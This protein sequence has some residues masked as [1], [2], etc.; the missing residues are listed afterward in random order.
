M[1]H[2][3]VRSLAVGD[4]ALEVADAKERQ[5]RGDHR[6]GQPLVIVGSV[7]RNQNKGE[8]WHQCSH[9][10]SDAHRDSVHNRAAE[11]F[12]GEAIHLHLGG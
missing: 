11:R 4:P 3:R 7:R 12:L 2:A 8:Q 5:R 1:G 6:G 10:K 9:Q